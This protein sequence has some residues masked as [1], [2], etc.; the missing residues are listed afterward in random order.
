MWT[1]LFNGINKQ[2]SIVYIVLA[3]EHLIVSNSFEMPQ[4]SSK[5]F[6]LVH[7]LFLYE[8]MSYIPIISSTWQ[9][10]S[11]LPQ[12]FVIKIFDV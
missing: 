10:K 3:Y 1:F 6:P 2:D 4:P 11:S 9:W 7:A 12:I 5:N 8:H